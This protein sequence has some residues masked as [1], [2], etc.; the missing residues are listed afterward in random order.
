MDL[1][2]TELKQRI[3]MHDYTID[4]DDLAEEILWKLKLF[5]R[6]RREMVEPSEPSES[7]RRRREPA[8]FW[9]HPEGPI[10][11]PDGRDQ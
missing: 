11:R 10:Q 4:A 7:G 3:A 5:S 2:V 9:P 1:E 8:H 6:I